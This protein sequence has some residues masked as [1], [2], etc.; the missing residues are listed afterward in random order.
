MSI[1][2]VCDFDMTATFVPFIAL[3]KKN[4]MFS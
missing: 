3:K 1:V 2:L 4:W